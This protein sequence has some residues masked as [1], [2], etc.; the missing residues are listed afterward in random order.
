MSGYGLPQA[1]TFPLHRPRGPRD[2]LL[3]TPEA[4]TSPVLPP[5]GSS[6]HAGHEMGMICDQKLFL[7][8][9]C[10]SC[11][12]FPLRPL[13]RRRTMGSAYVH[14]GPA[15]ARAALRY[16]LLEVRVQRGQRPHQTGRLDC[17]A[18]LATCKAPSLPA[19]LRPE[20]DQSP[21]RARPGRQHPAGQCPGRILA[22]LC[23]VPDR[24]RLHL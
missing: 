17:R 19:E 7:V 23:V 18:E 9:F 6:Q 20:A 5:A 15:R 12:I 24:E 3:W 11:S 10:C 8:V 2:D 13:V 4:A 14:R 1:Q 16:R 22:S 21:L